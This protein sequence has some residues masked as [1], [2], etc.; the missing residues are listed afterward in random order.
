MLAT[1]TINSENPHIG[2]LP[3]TDDKNLMPNLKHNQGL[4][5][6]SALK[7]AKNGLV[8][9]SKVISNIAVIALTGLGMA[10]AASMIGVGVAIVGGSLALGVHFMGPF[11]I[12]CLVPG[13][14]LGMRFIDPAIK[15]WNYS[16]K[17]FDLTFI[18]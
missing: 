16:L 5:I 2:A 8:I 6:S 9:V 14:M 7:V 10:L 15:I 3:D 1:T 18:R 4:S 12:I 11:G 13:V 17:F